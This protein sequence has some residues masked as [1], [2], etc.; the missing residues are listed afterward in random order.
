MTN[1]PKALRSWLAEEFTL[2][3]ASLVLNRH[4]A[5]VTDKLLLE[6]EDRS[7]IETVIIRVPQDGVGSTI[8]ARRSA[9]RPR[10]AARWA[11]SSARAGSPG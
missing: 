6:L 10:S 3:P 7:L 1:L 9:S 11:A 4:S 8:R 5:D 2:M